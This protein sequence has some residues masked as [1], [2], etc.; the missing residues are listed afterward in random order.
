M[1]QKGHIVT[2]ILH[3]RKVLLGVTG[4]IAAYKSPDI[5]RLL[6]KMGAD[7]RVVMSEAA[8]RFVTPLTFEALTREAVLYQQNENWRSEQNHI[9]WGKWADLLVIAPATANTINKLTAGIADTL[10]LQTVLAFQGPLVIAPAANPRMLEHPATER[11]LK[12]LQERGIQVIPSR[13][14]KLACLE[15]GNGAM[16]EVEEIVHV[17]A[18]MLLQDTKW[19]GKN[20]LLTGGGTQE[21]IDDVRV[22]ANRSSGKMANA[23]ALAFYYA[24]AD[25]MFV[26]SVFDS[27]PLRVKRYAVQSAAEMKQAVHEVIDMCPVSHVVAAAAVSDYVPKVQQSGKIKKAQQEEWSLELALNEDILESLQEWSGCKIGFK[28]EEDWENGRQAAQKMLEKKSLD[29][30]CLNVLADSPLGSDETTMEWV[31]SKGTESLHPGDKLQVAMQIVQKV[32]EL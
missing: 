19:S 15:E 1:E 8:E 26:S 5:V 23:L 28:L 27:L 30:V 16:G 18:R 10:L 3:G 20:V 11:S 14:S 13:F 7:V 12:R 2:K 32:A 22:I 21:K 17:C 31:S 4:S 25:V 29:A 9:D 6:S 24:G